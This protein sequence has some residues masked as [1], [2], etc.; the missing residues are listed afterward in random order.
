M[1]DSVHVS[2]PP[3]SVA[4]PA[5]PAPVVPTTPCEVCAHAFDLRA[6][7]CPR[8]GF[9]RTGAAALGTPISSKSPRSAMWLSVFWPGGGHFYG[10]D[11][12]RGAILT[13]VALVLTMLSAVLLGP[14]L[15][16]LLWL[17][18]SLYAAI[19]SGRLVSGSRDR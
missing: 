17:P 10:G 7:E 9:P 5:P 12:D 15:G 2:Q 18:L 1:A 8:C 3:P 11:N 14:A 6:A 19:D 16:L 4:P 13:V